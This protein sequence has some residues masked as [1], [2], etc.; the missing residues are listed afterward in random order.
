MTKYKMSLKKDALWE[1]SYRYKQAA[2]AEADLKEAE[3]LTAKCVEYYELWKE[4]YN[5]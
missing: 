4:S 2:K 3:K 1:M 5:D